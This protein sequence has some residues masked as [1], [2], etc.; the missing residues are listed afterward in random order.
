M[1]RIV[2]Q[3]LAPRIADL[4]ANRELAMAAIGAAVDAGADVVVLPELVTSGYVF[5]STEEAA[6][7]AV[8]PDHELFADWAA[9]AARGSA[10]VIGGFCELG[11]DGLL[12]NSAAL[13]DPSGVRAVYRK[14]HL[15]D[16]EKLVFEPG[17]QPPPVVDTHAGRIALLVCYDLEFPELTR[18]V[19]LA[20]ADLIAV[21]TNW[22]LVDRPAGE[23]APEVVIA[24]A[25]ARV[26]RVFVACCDRTGTERGQEWNAATTIVD[27]SGWVV[28]TADER[29]TATADVDLARARDKTLTEHS[30]ALGDR[31]PELYGAVAAEVSST[32]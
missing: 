20:G 23:R 2:C 8:A 21:P 5:A 15:W 4:P 18:T 9:E 13:V 22:P 24:M 25:A 1:T 26:N 3:Q 32:R 10:V 17:A 7:V 31:R 11:D 27:A 12:Y 28:A 19:A 29:G 16:R 14:T 30:D 6:S